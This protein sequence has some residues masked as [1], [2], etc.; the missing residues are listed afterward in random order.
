MFMTVLTM[1]FRRSKV[2]RELVHWWPERTH[3]DG[4][5]IT[6][7]KMPAILEKIQMVDS[8]LYLV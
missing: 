1:I 2:E 7:V 8:L 5:I 3:L 4:S 6:A